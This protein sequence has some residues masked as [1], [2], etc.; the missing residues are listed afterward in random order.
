MRNHRQDYQE[1][2]RR[3][4]SPPAPAAGG[5]HRHVLQSSPALHRNINV[6]DI[7]T[8]KSIMIYEANEEVK[9]GLLVISS[10]DKSNVR[11]YT[12]NQF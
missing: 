4:P 6:V 2:K 3:V 12:L 1:Q 5:S 10:E 8:F 7:N 9:L 11:F